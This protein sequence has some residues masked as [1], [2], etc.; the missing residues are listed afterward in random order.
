MG[1]TAT[2]GQWG[3]KKRAGMSLGDRRPWRR[4]ILQ[5]HL[6]NDFHEIIHI[7]RLGHVG[8]RTESLRPL[9]RLVVVQSGKTNEGNRGNCRV[10]LQLLQHGKTVFLMKFY[11]RNDRSEEHT[12]E[13]HSQF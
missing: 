4:E 8:S 11:I 2:R 12:S 6:P 5:Q 9:R 13:L 7:K 10:I 1:R 3:K